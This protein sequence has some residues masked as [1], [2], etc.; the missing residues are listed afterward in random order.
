MGLTAASE[1]GGDRDTAS[2]KLEHPCRCWY[3]NS[4]LGLTEPG[5]FLRSAGALPRNPTG[6]LM[7]RELK[8]FVAERTGLSSE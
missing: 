5:R 3:L 4:E 2:T 1:S 8:Q 6:K 7:K